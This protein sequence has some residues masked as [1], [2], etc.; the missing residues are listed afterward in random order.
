MNNYGNIQNKRNNF[1]LFLSIKLNN[2]LTTIRE[3]HGLPRDI[4]GKSRDTDKIN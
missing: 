2:N 1:T 4:F 3:K